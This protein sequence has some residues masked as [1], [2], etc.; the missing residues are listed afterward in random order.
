[1]QCFGAIRFD[2]DRFRRFLCSPL[3]CSCACVCSVLAFELQMA[4]SVW[5]SLVTD[6]VRHGVGGADAAGDGGADPFCV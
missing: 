6:A 2:F 3:L 1:M 4:A 5:A